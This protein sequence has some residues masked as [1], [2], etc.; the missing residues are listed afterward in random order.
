MCETYALTGGSSAVCGATLGQAITVASGGML[1][2]SAEPAWPSGVRSNAWCEQGTQL[3]LGLAST[4]DGSALD[5]VTS[6]FGEPVGD[7]CGVNLL[8]WTN[9]A[10]A[11]MNVTIVQ[12]C[13]SAGGCIGAIAYANLPHA[14]PQP[15]APAPLSTGQLPNMSPAPVLG[16]ASMPSLGVL[17]LSA[18]GA[19][20]LLLTSAAGNGTIPLVSTNGTWYGGSGDQRGALSAPGATVGGTLLLQLVN[21]ISATSVASLLTTSVTDPTG[22]G[23]S[24]VSGVMPPMGNV[25]PFTPFSMVG[26]RPAGASFNISSVAV[27][28]DGALQSS[29]VASEQLTCSVGAGAAAVDVSAGM[30]FLTC[31]MP[32]LQTVKAL[33]ISSGV[34]VWSVVVRDLGITAMSVSAGRVYFTAVSLTTLGIVCGEVTP[35]GA[36]VGWSDDTSAQGNP[37]LHSGAFVDGDKFTPSTWAAQLSLPY[38]ATQLVAGIVA[39]PAPI[40]DCSAQDDGVEV[41][42]RASDGSDATFVAA[43]F[44]GAALLA[45]LDGRSS[46]WQYDS[47]LWTGNGTLNA[48]STALDR[49]EAKLDAFNLLS[50]DALLLGMVHTEDGGIEWLTLPLGARYASMRALLQQ[51]GSAAG[52][53]PTPV[54]SSMWLALLG[55]NG[56]LP[57]QQYNCSVA[58]GIDVAPTEHSPRARVSMMARACD[59]GQV[60][61]ASSSSSTDTAGGL[62]P[63]DTPAQLVQQ[64]AVIGFGLQGS[65]G[66]RVTVGSL[67]RATNTN[68]PRFGFILGALL[69]PPPPPPPPPSPPL[70]SGGAYTNLTGLTATQSAAW[71]AYGSASSAHFAVDGDTVKMAAW[72]TTSPSCDSDNAIAVSMPVS[73]VA[74]LTIDLGD[75]YAVH[76]LYLWGRGNPLYYDLSLGCAPYDNCQSAG[77]SVYVGNTSLGSSTAAQSADTLLCAADVAAAGTGTK[78]ACTAVGRYVTLTKATTVVLSICQ[79]VV[80]A[81]VPANTAPPSPPPVVCPAK[82]YSGTGYDTDGQ[83][84][85]CTACPAYTVTNGNTAAAHTGAGACTPVPPP[86][87]QSTPLL[88][89]TCGN[90]GPYGPSL[91]SCQAAY[92]SQPLL[93]TL[94]ISAPFGGQPLQWQT[95]RLQQ[96][97]MYNITAAGAAGIGA[98]YSDRCRGAVLSVIAKLPADSVLYVMVGQVGHVTGAPDNFNGD[99]GAGGG[100]F[101]LSEDGSPLVV[102]GGGGGFGNAPQPKMHAGCDASLNSTSGNPSADGSPGGT[103]GLAGTGI[104]SGGGL[105]TGDTGLGGTAALDGGYGGIP[106]NFDFGGFGG[107]GQVGGGGG[108]YSGGGSTQNCCVSSGGGGGSYCGNTSFSECALGYNVGDGF[109]RVELVSVLTATNGSLVPAVPRAGLTSYFSAATWSGGVWTDVINNNSGICTGIGF[110]LVEAEVGNGASV[111]V[112]YVAGTTSSVVTFGAAGSVAGTNSVCSVSR[113]LSGAQGRILQSTSVNWWQGHW[114]GQAGTS[115]QNDKFTS[116]GNGAGSGLVYPNTDWVWMCS[117]NAANTCAVYVNGVNACAAP[118]G[119]SGPEQLGINVPASGYTPLSGTGEQSAWGVAEL[120]VWNRALTD[121]EFNILTCYFVVKYGFARPAGVACAPLPTPPPPLPPQNPIPSSPLAPECTSYVVL[122]GQS[123]RRFPGGSSDVSSDASLATAWYRFNDSGWNYLL[124]AS[125]GV[126]SAYQCGGSAVGGYLITPPPVAGTACIPTCFAGGFGS[127]ESTGAPSDG[128][129]PAVGTATRCVNVTSC[130]SYYVYYLSAVQGCTGDYNLGFCTSSSSGV[131]YPPPPLPPS[132]LPTNLTG[133]T[134]TQSATWV[135]SSASYA[136]DGDTSRYVGA[137]RAN[138]S[139]NCDTDS[140]I[141]VS[142]PVNGVAW[143][144]VDL[145]TV[146]AVQTVFVYGRN[147]YY[148]TNNSCLADPV[149]GYNCQ[150]GGLTLAV[151]NSSAT[152]GTGNPVCAYRFDATIDGNAVVCNMVGRYVTIFKSVTQNVMSVCQVVVQATSSL[153]PSPS[154]P[155]LNPSL[156]S[157]PSSRSGLAGYYTVASF[158]ASTAGVWADASGNGA[159]AQYTGSL[160]LL[161]AQVGNGSTTSVAAVAGTTATSVLFASA[162]DD[163]NWTVCGVARYTSGQAAFEGYRSSI[164]RIICGSN[165]N[166]LLGHWE[167]NTGVAYYTPSPGWVVPSENGGLQT[168]GPGNTSWVFICGSSASTFVNG[169]RRGNGGGAPGM[170]AVNGATAIV[171]GCMGETSDFAVAELAIWNRTLSDAEMMAVQAHQAVLLFGG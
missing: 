153:S 105:Y 150:S 141:A 131:V 40:T 149:N 2:A 142:Q 33:N 95:I 169:V 17:L 24:V 68:A 18:L 47:M 56:A 38:D 128:C 109:A 99:G 11:P 126:P 14:S 108:G 168:G 154:P 101:V 152:G 48:R 4:A 6:S 34:V 111:G 42:M 63:K 103:G 130:G 165:V 21:A 122:K 79:V 134:A 31:G 100:T 127:C 123:Y 50:I 62:W 89:T 88:L 121:S 15:P 74:S 77:I 138:V 140:V 55:A 3:Y 156:L 155:P 132:P 151:G 119:G 60:D 97:G 64:W 65:N 164:R 12:Q 135:S 83:G 106:F 145:Q 35:G 84:T 158:A 20:S 49:T 102:A 120:L 78:L 161:P 82:T 73:G 70:A 94:I 67:V 16:G 113:Y 57:M 116:S 9:S 10:G 93:S 52:V 167:G 87:L 27:S 124:T 139:P 136:V 90:A 147:P 5:G 114:N 148:Y 85:G 76:A 59:T 162:S 28:A 53:Y 115:W 137:W 30:M 143:L 104:W 107:G 32:P 8:T 96:T 98:M 112:S 117:T 171:A 86:S 37:W 26:L 43:C 75:V 46:A 160:T 25:F 23:T 58:Q 71:D 129:H 110:S 146:Q 7:T 22:F 61:Y 41:M 81:N 170:V 118:F 133:L 44:G 29:D 166:W 91:E 159:D 72:P 92:Q 45:K 19:P 125:V 1:T 36:F 80:E 51:A 157:P 13:L 39:L 144:M 66:S 163:A 54:S 69:P